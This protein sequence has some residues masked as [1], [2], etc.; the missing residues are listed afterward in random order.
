MADMKPNAGFRHETPDTIPYAGKTKLN[1]RAK[2]P[3]HQKQPASPPRQDV[4]FPGRGIVPD[5]LSEHALTMRS[6]GCKSTSEG[7]TLP[8]AEGMAPAAGRLPA[9]ELG[10]APDGG[11]GGAG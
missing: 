5:V 11:S 8:G 7:G 9:M 3:I 6:E 2:V 10:Q 4:S 1:P